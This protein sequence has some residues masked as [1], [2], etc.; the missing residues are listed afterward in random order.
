MSRKFD[1][2]KSAYERGTWNKQMVRNAVVKSWITA[3]EY[4]LITG[5]AYAE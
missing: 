2:V 3:E 1:F 4:E 5:E